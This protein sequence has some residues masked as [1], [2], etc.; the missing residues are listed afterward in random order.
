MKILSHALQISLG[1]TPTEFAFHD[2]RD[3][4]KWENT[5]RFTR[6]KNLVETS[7]LCSWV[8]RR[9]CCFAYRESGDRQIHGLYS[10]NFEATRIKLS[11][12]VSLFNGSKQMISSDN[13]VNKDFTSAQ[14]FECMYSKFN[15]QTQTIMIFIPSTIIYSNFSTLAVEK[16]LKHAWM[17]RAGL[18]NH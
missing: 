5:K 7:K 17:F 8:S 10:S 11:D 15:L 3:A 13:N 14:I 2:Q 4:R 9:R 1:E 12:F 16:R 18:N 6:T